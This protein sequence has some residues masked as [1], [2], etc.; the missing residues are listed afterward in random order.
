MYL[1]ITGA[2]DIVYYNED[3]VKSRFHCT[4]IN[5][6]LYMVRAEMY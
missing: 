4:T 1:T 5:Y 2:K 3:F 6:T